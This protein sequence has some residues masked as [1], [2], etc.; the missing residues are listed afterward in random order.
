MLFDSS[1]RKELG[2]SFG[3][4]AVVLVTIVMT[5][6]LIRTLSHAARGQVNPSEVMLVMGFTVL[7]HLPT[8]LTLSLF[9]ATTATLTR[10]YASSEMVVWFSCG[11]G[12]LSFARPVLRFAAPVLLAVA[13]LALLVWPWSNLQINELR[14]RY[15]GRGDLE[16]V[17]PGHFIESQ[18]GQRV[19]FIDKDSPDDLT[20]NNIFITATEK[21]RESVTTA[22]SGRIE[23]IENERFLVLHRGQQFARELANGTMRLSHFERYGSRI[24][25]TVPGHTTNITPRLLSTPTLLLHPTPQHQ[26]ELSW[27][28]G[29]VLAAL[30][31]ALIALAATRVN[32]RAGRSASLVFSLAAFAVYYNLLTMGENWITR[33][34]IGMVPYMVLLHGS[35]FVAAM[36]WLLARNGEWLMRWQLRRAA[37][38]QQE[39]SPEAVEAQA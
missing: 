6:M 32:P 2:R 34:R 24:D 38:Q 14:G 7:G 26:G 11:Q 39:Q 18:G 3:A 23:T 33:S 31:C 9:V 21:G 37:R 5:V 19:F 17:A 22:E 29:L 36:L 1:L 25:E 13:V 15:Q 27:R 20:G 8:I 28:I 30:N 16:R 4:T 12:L 35:I 10:M